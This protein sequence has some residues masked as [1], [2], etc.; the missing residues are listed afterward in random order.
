MPAGCQSRFT[1]KAG[2]VEVRNRKRIIKADALESIVAL[3]GALFP[4]IGVPNYIWAID[5][6]K[7]V[8]EV[9]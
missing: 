6:R 1:G 5:N 2:S 3:L 4:L 8:E 9:R 7:F